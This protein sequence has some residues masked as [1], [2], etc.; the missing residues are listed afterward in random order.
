[1]CNNNIMNEF[2]DKMELRFMDE[3][4]EIERSIGEVIGVASL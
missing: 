4:L 3:M 2:E 1:M